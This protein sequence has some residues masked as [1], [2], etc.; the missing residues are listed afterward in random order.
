MP[1]LT[2]EGEN[3]FSILHIC[4]RRSILWIPDTPHVILTLEWMF[5]HS[6]PCL[7][8]VSP[9]SPSIWMFPCVKP[10]WCQIWAWQH[11]GVNLEKP[12]T[13]LVTWPTRCQQRPT[14]P[15]LE[16]PFHSMCECL[17]TQDHTSNGGQSDLAHQIYTLKNGCT[18][19][20]LPKLAK[21]LA[22]C[23]QHPSCCILSQ[24]HIKTPP[25]GAE[26]R[27]DKLFCNEKQLYVHFPN[28]FIKVRCL[29]LALL[30]QLLMA[31]L[32]DE[33]LE[34]LKFLPSTLTKIFFSFKKEKLIFL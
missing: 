34:L 26:V 18:W 5:A 14:F 32:W 13:T 30:E 28:N 15:R 11:Q 2:Q 25:Y 1:L 9:M 8:L 24:C 6:V 21:C 17:S 20:K 19:T 27:R 10:L 29:R 12:H 3:P 7:S 31:K 22:K 23:T 4:T 16:L 33:H